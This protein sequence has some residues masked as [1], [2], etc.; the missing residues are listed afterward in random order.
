[1]SNLPDST[2]SV[3][4]QLIFLFIFK[5]EKHSNQIAGFFFL[6]MEK[7]TVDYNFSIEI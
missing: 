3:A 1:M 7:V 4:V 6:V 2:R 5:H